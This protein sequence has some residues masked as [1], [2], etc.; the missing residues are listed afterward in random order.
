M[1]KKAAINKDMMIVEVVNSYPQTF[2]I[3]EKYGMHCIYC[4]ASMME[5]VEQAAMV[6]GVDVEK[7][8]KELNKAVKEKKE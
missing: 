3:F 2:Q 5:T 6:H 4:P 1:G 7:L 8:L